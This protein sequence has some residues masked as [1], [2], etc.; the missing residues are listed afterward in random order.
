MFVYASTATRDDLLTDEDW[1]HI[2]WLLVQNPAAG[3][4]I[5][6]LSGTRKL[7][8]RLRGRGKR[9]GARTIY[10]YVANQETV[11]F[12]ATYVKNEQTD[13][14]PDDKR[15]LAQLIARIKEGRG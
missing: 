8:L 3:V 6:D 4:L 1:Q 11:Y 10:L 14:T 15:V 2:E 5:P 12:L 13:L 9:G 7:R